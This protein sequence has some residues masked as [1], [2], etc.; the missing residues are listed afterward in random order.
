M[1]ISVRISHT[2]LWCEFG[3]WEYSPFLRKVVTVR[4]PARSDRCGSQVSEGASR[5]TSEWFE[6]IRVW[7]SKTPL[8]VKKLVMRLRLFG[9]VLS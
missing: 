5:I 8:D 6:E 1:S 7:G 4:I 3:S 9:K 2:P